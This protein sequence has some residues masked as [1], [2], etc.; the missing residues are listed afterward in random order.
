M[1]SEVAKFLARLAPLVEGSAVWGDSAIPLRVAY[2]L[3]RE[4]PPLEYVTSAR[5]VVFRG[6]EVMVVRDRED[7]FHV[8]PGGRVEESE[9]PEDALRREVLE[10][11]GWTLSRVAYIGF[12]H[13]RHL[14]PKPAGYAYPY[15]DF[16]QAIYVAEAEAFAPEPVMPGEYE[17]ETGFRPIDE[18]RTLALTLGQRELLDA[19]LSLRGSP[20]R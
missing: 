14:A 17:L 10:E 8:V 6:D 11:T 5:A 18:A 9:T 16:F 12:V 1:A 4:L 7:S 2:Y 3:T 15:P 13:Y 20:P 19:A